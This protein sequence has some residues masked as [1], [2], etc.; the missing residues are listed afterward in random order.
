M[1]NH[2]MPPYLRAAFWSVSIDKLDLKKN[3][4]YVINQVLSLGDLDMWQWLFDIYSKSEVRAVFVTHPSKS[5]TD[6]RFYFIKN[7]LLNIK[8]QELNPN[9]YV[10]HLPRDIPK[11]IPRRIQ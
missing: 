7:F 9:R 2:R 8:N 3:K 5:Y 10:Q 11:K 1:A 4:Q 6:S